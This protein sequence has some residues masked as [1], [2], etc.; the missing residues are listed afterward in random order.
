VIV[1]FTSFDNAVSLFFEEWI[2]I[3]T[4]PILFG[5]AFALIFAYVARFMA[6][7]FGGVESALQKVTPHMDDAART[8]GKG[9]WE[10]LRRVHLPMIWGGI[11]AG[12]ILVFVDCMKE[13]PATLILRPPFNFDTLAT[14]V[15]QYASDEA[16]ELASLGAITIVLAGILPVILLAKAIR[17]TRPGHEAG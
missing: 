8:L 12:A 10:T 9:P 7:G 3:R 2:G 4:G 5:T 6:I 15:Y 14:F 1:P 11:L 16:F 13:L 17:S